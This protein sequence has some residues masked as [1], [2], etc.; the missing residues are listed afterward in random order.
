[1]VRTHV[2]IHETQVKQFQCHDNWVD[3]TQLVHVYFDRQVY[4]ISL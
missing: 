2:L 1:M 4:Q 3:F